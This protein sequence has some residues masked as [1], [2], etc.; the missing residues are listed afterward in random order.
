M[1]TY[2]IL[3][4]DAKQVLQQLEKN[5]VQTCITSPPYWGLRDYGDPN[6]LGQEETPEEYIA[7]LVMVFREV[8]RVL[9]K[10]GTL[11]LNLGDSYWGGKGMNGNT[12]AR[13][14]ADERGAI[15]SKGTP[16]QSFRPLDGKHEIIK[17]KELCGIPW[18]TALALQSEGWY[19]RQDIIWSKPNPMPESVKDRCTRAHEYM[20]MLTKSPRYYYDA[21]VIKE[22]MS[23]SSIQRLE[24]DIESQNGSI[25]VV[26]KTNGTMK[27]VG[28]IDKQRGHGRRH[29]GFNE[30]CDLMAKEGQR[31][32]MRNKRSV[33][34]VAT[35][36]YDGDHYATFPPEL[37]KPCILAGSPIGGTVLDPF[38]GTGT[39]AATAMELGR[40]AVLCEL[41]PQY[42][43]L[44][45]QRCDPVARQLQ[46][47]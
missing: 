47:F 2:S 14:T 3:I 8:W 35:K 25:R 43:P 12:K 15:Q 4:G 41:N 34:T 27:A 28:K 39:T 22:P 46:M 31:S 30:R 20:F 17:P 45:Q 23:L 11:W 19:L 6:Q 29:A 1:P 44:I 24:Q 36:P 13:N 5:S 21:E 9:R 37:I 26:G 16:L 32:G 40:N 10:D 38:G 33:W 18:R 7:N 42:L